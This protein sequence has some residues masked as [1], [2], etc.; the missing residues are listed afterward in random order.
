MPNAIK[1]PE[2]TAFLSP[3]DQGNVESGGAKLGKGARAAP[4][5]FGKRDK[6]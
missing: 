4:D 3:N 6:G 2:S 1:K 5:I